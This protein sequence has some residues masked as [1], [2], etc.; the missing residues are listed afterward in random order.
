MFGRQPEASSSTG[1]TCFFIRFGSADERKLIVPS[2]ASI[3]TEWLYLKHGEPKV[4]EAV[5]CSLLS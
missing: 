1:P 4:C 3:E 5:M 2:R